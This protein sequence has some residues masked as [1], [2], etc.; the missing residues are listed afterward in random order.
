MK[1]LAGNVSSSISFRSPK[2][3][4]S[5]SP[6]PTKAV[7]AKEKDYYRDDKKDKEKEDRRDKKEEKRVKKDKRDHK[8]KDKH[9]ER[10][11]EKEHKE[12]K[13]KEGK[14]IKGVTE[15][16][17]KDASPTN[18]ASMVPPT[19]DKVCIHYHFF[20]NLFNNPTINLC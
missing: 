3:S 17:N 9:K 2:R 4:S 18:I 7:A 5:P 6:A 12:H 20:Q 8:D 10:D 1:Y 14:P 16:K 19:V 13:N 11:K 15:F